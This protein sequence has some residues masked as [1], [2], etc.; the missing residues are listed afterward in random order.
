MK[1]KFFIIYAFILLMVT[2]CQ[3]NQQPEYE[4][5][6]NIRVTKLGFET[7]QL[8]AEAIFNNPNILGITIKRSDIDV[9]KD[10]I[11]LGKAQ[12]P[13]F[14]VNKKSEFK[15]PITIDFSPKKIIKEKGFLG[16]ILSTVSKKELNITYKGIITLD[17]LGIEYDYDF[18][19]TEPIVLKKEK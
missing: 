17:V 4:R 2:G 18:E 6:E 5:M 7:I 12:T 14:E 11:F 16:N 8:Q 19:H 1:K 3:I 9:F 10:S 13:S 15:I